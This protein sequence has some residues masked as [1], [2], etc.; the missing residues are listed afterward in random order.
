MGAFLSDG[1]GFNK[2]GFKPRRRP[3]TDERGI[4]GDQTRPDP[5]PWLKLPELDFVDV[6]GQP[7]RP[8]PQQQPTEEGVPPSSA[9][10]DGTEITAKLEM[11][12]AQMKT[13]V[14]QGNL[15]YAKRIEDEM[16]QLMKEE[17]FDFNP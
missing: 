9:R 12:R 5:L 11:L 14:E 2:S 15:E 7:K 10:R 6:A 4:A 3:T 13:E 17:G 8:K 16:L 1:S